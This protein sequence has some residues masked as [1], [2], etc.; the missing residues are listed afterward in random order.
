MVI[1]F[2]VA[3]A[4]GM[5]LAPGADPHPVVLDYVVKV[6]D[7][8]QG[9]LD[10]E[11]DI[12]SPDSRS[13][14]L[15]FSGHAVSDQLPRTRYRVRSAQNERGES[16]A[17]E[18]HQ[19]GWRISTKKAERVH[20]SYD[21]R[22]RFGS[23]NSGF[24]QE[25][26]SRCDVEGARLLGSDVFLFPLGREAAAIGARYELPPGWSLYHPFAVDEHTAQ[27]PS[28]HSLYSSVVAAGPYRVA[29]RSLAGCDLTIAIQGQFA[30]GDDDL[31]SMIERVVARELEFFGSTPR[32]SYLFVVNP[33]PR[34]SD[35]DNLRYFGLHFDASM[36]IL[37]DERTDYRRLQAEPAQICA[38]EFFHN[39][40][41]GLIKQHGYD[42]NWFIEGVTTYYSYQFRMDC[43]M[44]DPGTYAATVRERFERDVL[45]SG[46]LG[47][48]SLATV[49]TQVLQAAET[50]SFLYSGGLVV[51]KALDHEI[52]RRTNNRRSLDDVM[53]NLVQKA[54]ANRD[55]ILTREALEA[56]LELITESSM[57]EWLARY[58]YGLETP[59]LDAV[60]PAR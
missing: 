5:R 38:H 48:S 14:I 26:L 2:A 12:E 31:V 49:S 17:I 35:P 59:P 7:A 9:S 11:L 40:N 50:T 52:E 28:L 18:P 3:V 6:S 20:I 13:L 32:P 42:M 60:D 58:V 19:N 33:H 27:Y 29:R 24:S 44:L 16:L 47:H 36:M 54:Q 41:G 57:T 4:V 25:V 53:R 10:V 22:L 34:S 45:N 21:V 15:G 37:L 43:R 1:V 51:A 39:W 46:L 55:F 8:A 30:F 56:E 23:D